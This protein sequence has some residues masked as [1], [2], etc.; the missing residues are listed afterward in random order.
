MCG[1]DLERLR[2]QWGR[3]F[4]VA[5]GSPNQN[6]NLKPSPLQWGRDFSVAE[7]CEALGPDNGAN[8][9]Q[10]GRDFSV[11]EGPCTCLDP[12]T[13]ARFN[14][15]ATLVSRKV[16]PAG[17]RG[18]EQR[19]FN[20]AATLVSRKAEPIACRPDFSRPASMGPRL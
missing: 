9:L 19:R 10:W 11:A 20:G 2:L 14:G 6:P 17:R 12:N 7:G 3:D 16:S 18:K 4:S 5:E 13:A 8:Q 1:I 15:A